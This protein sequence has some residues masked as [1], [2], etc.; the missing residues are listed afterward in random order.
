MATVKEVF[1]EMPGMEFDLDSLESL[2]NDVEKIWVNYDDETDSMVMYFTGAPVRSISVLLKD[3][4]YVMVDP[5]TR[6]AVGVHFECWEKKFVP[7]FKPVKR[8]WP[9]V[10]PNL[11]AGWSYLLQMLMVWLITAMRQHPENKEMSLQLA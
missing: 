3:N 7:A 1:G 2:I 4:F 11:T 5:V 9:E 6:K 10:K 8:A